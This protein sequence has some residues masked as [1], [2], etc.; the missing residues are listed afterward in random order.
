MEISETEDRDSSRLTVAWR[1]EKK[2]NLFESQVLA[3]YLLDPGGGMGKSQN[4][5]WWL[6]PFVLKFPVLQ[7]S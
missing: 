4:V 6:F 7:G 1:G 3:P 2:P 5:G